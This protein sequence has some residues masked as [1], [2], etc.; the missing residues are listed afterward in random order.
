MDGVS[1]DELLNQTQEISLQIQHT[2]TRQGRDNARKF[3]D[4]FMPAICDYRNY[5]DEKEAELYLQQTS[6][7][8]EESKT[9]P[10]P[11]YVPAKMDCIIRRAGGT[12]FSVATETLRFGLKPVC[13]EFFLPK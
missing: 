12:H 6:S 1:L 8:G 7:L 4:V 13:A 3:V 11:F 10:F 9:K 2:V 5:V